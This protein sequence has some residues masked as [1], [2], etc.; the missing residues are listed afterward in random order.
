MGSTD[1][2]F[3]NTAEHVGIIRSTSGNLP[4]IQQRIASHKKNLGSILYAGM[5]R[6]HRANPLSSLR[7]EKTF[8]LPVLFS[9]MGAL[10]LTKPEKDIISF[11]VKSTTENLLKLH[12]TAHC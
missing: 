5:S 2:K 11:Y 9:G 6:R 4:H 10:I 12:P 8:C 7:A 3:V 1:I